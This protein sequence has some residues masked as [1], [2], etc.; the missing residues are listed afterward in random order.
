[1]QQMTFKVGGSN[2][3]ANGLQGR[4]EQLCKCQQQQLLLSSWIWFGEVLSL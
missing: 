2:Y 4:W 1:M 3:A